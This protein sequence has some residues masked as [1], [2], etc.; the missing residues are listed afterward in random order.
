MLQPK[1]GFFAIM[2]PLEEGGKNAADIYRRAQEQLTAVGLTVIAPEL[3]VKDD[4]TVQ[5]AVDLFRIENVDVLLVLEITWSFDTLAIDVL[6][7]IDRPI[8]TWAIP[9]ISNG[10]LCGI[11]QLDAVLYEIGKPYFFIYGPHDDAKVYRQIAGHAQ[12]AAL[13]RDL[14]ST[15]IGLVGYR[16]QG[17]TEVTLDELGIIKVLGPRIV[18]ISWDTLLAGEET[19]HANE[20]ESEWQ[21]TKDLVGVV[22]VSEAD[23]MNAMRKFL[24]LK[25]IV[26]QERLSAVAL[27]CYPDH[28][29]EYCLAF[30]RLAE[31]GVMGACEGDTNAAIAMHMLHQL[32]GEPVNNGDFLGHVPDDDTILLSHCG[33][34]GFMAAPSSQSIELAPV[35]LQHQ[36]VCCLFPHKPG[37][38]TLVNLAGR[39][40]TFR[41]TIIES[42]AVE[43]DLVFPGNP[44]RAKLPLPFEQFLRIIADNGVGHHWMGVSGHVGEVLMSFCKLRNILCLRI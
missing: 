16:M 13:V 19:I 29:G 6:Q 36:G 8:I 39:E 9:G 21:K 31:Q 25:H 14:K 33:S 24:A 20:V 18:H 44:L 38:V 2:H 32:T 3:I 30:S 35:R 15:R 11:Q 12:A 27:E 22:K 40:R 4:S 43:T 17:M 42:E 34:T 7:Q 10:S 26:E 23:G 5:A 37:P 28:M 1:I 41:M